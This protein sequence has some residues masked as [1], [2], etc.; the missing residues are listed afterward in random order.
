MWAIHAEIVIASPRFAA[1]GHDPAGIGPPAG[2]VDLKHADVVAVRICRA[3]MPLVRP[4]GE[5]AVHGGQWQTPRHRVAEVQD[6]TNSDRLARPRFPR[7][8]CVWYNPAAAS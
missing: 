1:I 2:L 7:S 8:Y 6:S 4:E 3:Q 5:T